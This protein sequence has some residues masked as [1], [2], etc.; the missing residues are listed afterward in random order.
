MV[1]ADGS[2][3]HSVPIFAVPSGQ[4]RTADLDVADLPCGRQ[5]FLDA[6]EESSLPIHAL[7]GIVWFITKEHLE[8]GRP[9]GAG[10]PSAT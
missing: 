10:M 7:A 9:G 4:D 1:H 5:N 6:M 2:I 3:W 8:A